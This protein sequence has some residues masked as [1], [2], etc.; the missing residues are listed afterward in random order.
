MVEVKINYS[1]CNS[2]KKCVEACAYG[3][4]EW[5]EDQPAVTNPNNCT[6]CLECTLNCPVEAI[7][8]KK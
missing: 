1:R 6:M 5:F 8:V 3:V 2:C 4:L 7:S